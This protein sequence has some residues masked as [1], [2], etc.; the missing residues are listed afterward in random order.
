[1]RYTG[2]YPIKRKIH[3]NA[4]ELDGLPPSVPA[5]QN[6]SYLRLFFPSPPKFES[7]P[8]PAKASGPLQIRDHQEW[9]V[10]AITQDRIV[11]GQRQYRLKWKDHDEQT[12]VRVSQL[13]HCAEMLREYQH[14]HNIALDFWDESSSSPESQSEDNISDS[15]RE[16]QDNA[17]GTF[18]WQDN[19][20]PAELETS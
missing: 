5:T 1:M 10:E 2:P 14:E 6:V 8:E 11:F 15:D 12:W 9:E 18:N 13:Q 17:V 20:D 19:E 3:D 4:Y 16:D 7:R